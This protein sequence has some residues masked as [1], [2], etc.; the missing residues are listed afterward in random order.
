MDLAVWLRSLGLEFWC[1]VYYKNPADQVTKGWVNAYYLLTSDGVR[2]G[3]RFSQPRVSSPEGQ[4][5]RTWCA[6][7][8][9]Y[10]HRIRIRSEHSPVHQ[11]QRYRFGRCDVQL[12]INVLKQRCA[13]SGEWWHV[14]EH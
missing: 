4:H 8:R 12:C 6:Q 13:D 5:P 7:R 1:P 2:L 10:R 11:L 9:L 14:S 3:E